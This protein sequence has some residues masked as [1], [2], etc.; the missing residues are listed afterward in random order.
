LTIS[1]AFT[2]H[3]RDPS[4][5][6]E[7]IPKAP[8]HYEPVAVADL[9]QDDFLYEYFRVAVTFVMGDADLSHMVR[10]A[11]VI[12]FVLML[13]AARRDLVEKRSAEV[14]LSDYG[15]VWRFRRD[16]DVV[17]LTVEE[18]DAG[19]PVGE[20]AVGECTFEEFAAAVPAAIDQA[21]ALIFSIQPRARENPYLRSLAE[22]VLPG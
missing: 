3:P 22:H 4:W 7:W 19:I 20:S 15:D 14:Q 17:R 10:N 12:D 9:T 16:A 13:E 18:F 6:A 21:V 1:I 2:P 8:P 11:F 5:T